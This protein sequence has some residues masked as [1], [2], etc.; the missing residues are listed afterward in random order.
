MAEK[1]IVKYVV[2]KVNGQPY[3]KAD[4]LIEELP[5]HIHRT[6]KRAAEVLQ[7]RFDFASV[8]ATAASVNDASRTVSFLAQ[9]ET[10]FT[11][12]WGK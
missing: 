5:T 12:A 2:K 9:S 10:G 3:M 1:W 11:D 4:D 7:E 6:V 8:R